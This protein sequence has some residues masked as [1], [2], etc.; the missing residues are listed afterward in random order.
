MGNLLTIVVHKASIHDTKSG[1]FPA[2]LSYLKY[3]TIKG[4]SAD[5][6]Y[7]GTF[8]EQVKRNLQLGVDISLKIKTEGFH[9]I[10]R[11]WVVERTFA[12]FNHSRRLSKDYEITTNSEEAMIIIS[13]CHTLIKL[14]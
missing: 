13:H 9:V 2:L 4:Y 14:L 3:P 1:I 7:R 5:G 8:I 10:P 11:R 6:G 12:W